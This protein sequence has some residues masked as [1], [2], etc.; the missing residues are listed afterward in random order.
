MKRP[1]QIVVVV[2]VVIVA[3]PL[4]F[5]L[6]WAFQEKRPLN[7]LVLNKTVP[8]IERETHRSL[9][10]ILNNNRF[11]KRDGGST[12]SYKKDYYGFFPLTPV[13]ERQYK[14]RDYRLT[15]LP[16]LYDNY[17]AL[18]FADTY[19]VFFDDWYSVSRSRTR[20]SRLIYGGLN[21]N[22]RLLMSEMQQRG[23][24]VILEYNSFDYPTPDLERFMVEEMLGIESTGW[25]GR[26]FSTLDTLRGSDLPLWMTSIYRRHTGRAWNY[27]KPGIVLVSN[28]QIVVLEYETHLLEEYP[29]IETRDNYAE[30]FGVEGSVPFDRWFQVIYPGDTEVI[31][32]FRI[33]TTSE[34][35]ML[36]ADHLLQN[37]FPAVISNPAGL[38]T[39][40]FAGD[41]A[42]NDIPYLSSYFYRLPLMERLRYSSDINDPRRFFWLYYRPL[43]TTIFSDYKGSIQGR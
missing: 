9:F 43:V 5:Y 22:D 23:K 33:K 38:N 25:T 40:Y 14:K 19:G 11:V 12:Y 10:W 21:S 17:D 20:R 35:E 36:L 42:T 37:R 4:F 1:L 41:F 8:S 2:L 16:D 7:V 29:F 3:V 32:N 26:Y 6:R 39:W 30:R 13:R 15:E 34:G 27:S 24:L 31:S 28:N 18:Y